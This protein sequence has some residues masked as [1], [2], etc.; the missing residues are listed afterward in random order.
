MAKIDKIKEKYKDTISTRTFNALNKGDTTDTK[1]YL[2]YMCQI[3]GEIRNSGHV[4]SYIKEFD[5]LLPYIENKDIYSKKYRDVNYL[6]SSIERAREIREEKTFKKSDH[7]ETIIDDENVLVLYIKT[8]RGSNKYGKNTRWC[9]SGDYDN[10]FNSYNKS[11]Y[12]IFLIHKHSNRKYAILIN[13]KNLNT[14]KAYNTYDTEITPFQIDISGE[15]LSSVESSIKVMEYIGQTFKFL[16]S[17]KEIEDNLIK[18]KSFIGNINKMANNTNNENIIDVINSLINAGYKGFPI[19]EIK[20][21]NNKLSE[22]NSI[23]NT[24]NKKEYTI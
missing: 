14:I 9:I 21:L 2:D 3:W 24:I 6:Y 7:I 13:R 1:K 4:I 23:I 18:Y 12:I 8:K 19:D 16:N 10:R 17:F 5:E 11:N 22:L 15:T 20:T